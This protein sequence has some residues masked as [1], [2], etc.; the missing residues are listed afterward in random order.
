MND[1]GLVD[2][3]VD[4]TGLGS[5]DG[6]ADLHGDRTGL[7]VR[8]EAAGTEDFTQGTH[9]GHHGRST[10]DDVHIRP[11]TFDLL[12]VLV[13]AHVVGAGFLGLVLLVRSA[14]GEDA[15][16]LTRSVRKGDH[17]TDHLVGLARVNAQI[18]GDLDGSVELGVR[19]ILYH[20]ARLSERIQ[21]VRIEL[22]SDCLLI[23]SHSCHNACRF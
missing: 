19:D 23:L 21:L 22:L 20:L 5:L 6:S 10:D 18:R 3:E 12:D 9:L 13:Q 16:H 17:A 11:A 4:L 2:L 14:E 15:H 7:G 8:H 1:T